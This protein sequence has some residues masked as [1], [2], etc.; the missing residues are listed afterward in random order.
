MVLILSGVEELAGHF[1]SDEQIDALLDEVAFPEINLNQQEHVDELNTLCHAYAEMVGLDFSDLASIDFFQRLA[2][3]CADRWGLVIELL[4]NA[5]V[6][7]VLEGGDTIRSEHFCQAFTKGTRYRP[8]IS[9]FSI[10][11]FEKHFERQKLAKLWDE[12]KKAKR[13][14]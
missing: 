6:N 7:A 10:S 12:R 2:L 13:S 5:L 1:K 3:A 11:D 4:I 9:P 8:G 14:E